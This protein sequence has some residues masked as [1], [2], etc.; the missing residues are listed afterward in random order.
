MELVCPSCEARYRV[1]DGAIGERGRRVS[2]TN[3]GHD[4][5]AVPPLMRAALAETGDTGAP[6]ESVYG[7]EESE[8]DTERDAGHEIG[9]GAAAEIHRLGPA[10]PSRVA[11]LA[12]IREMIAQV[13]SED[14]ARVS[15]ARG[16]RRHALD[17]DDAH[18]AVGAAPPVAAGM[19][20]PTSE[21]RRDD[22]DENGEPQHQDPLRRRM[23]E[24]DA[25]AARERDERDRL[26]RS[27][28]YRRRESGSGSG[29]FLA[30]FLLVVLVAAA[31]VS[32]YL[33]HDEIMARVPESA[34][35][36]TEYAAAVDDLRLSI[37]E[38]YKQ[39]RAWVIEAADWA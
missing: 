7:E 21:L 11:Q 38:T 18:A 27:M 12:E 15:R 1:P 20:R 13:Q 9:H 4:W 17:D 5:H 23:A 6:A 31:L 22:L 39:A 30:G 28:A 35:A 16:D 29:A 14:G 2:C 8:P 25:R 26:R 34:P 37:A 19:A 3:C 32:A 24:H 10:E 33:L 36:L